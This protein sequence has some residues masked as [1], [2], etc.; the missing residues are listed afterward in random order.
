MSEKVRCG[1]CKR[2]LTDPK[3]VKRGYGSYCYKKEVQRREYLKIQTT[4]PLEE[5]SQVFHA[6]ACK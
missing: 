5:Q 6:Y 1:R 2:V 3:S 4:L